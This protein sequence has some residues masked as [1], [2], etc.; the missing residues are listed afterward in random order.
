MHSY[1]LTIERFY[2][3][4]RGIHPHDAW[5]YQQ[6]G[7][8]HLI[9]AEACTWPTE[10]IDN[11]INQRQKWAESHITNL[12]EHGL[13]P[14]I[15]QLM[16][17]QLCSPEGAFQHR[18]STPDRWPHKYCWLWDTA[19][20]AVGWRHFDAECA[21]EQIHALFDQQQEDG[22][23]A[24]Y[25]TPNHTSKISQPPVLAWAVKESI[26][27]RIESCLAGRYLS[28]PVCLYGM[29][30]C[31]ARAAESPLLH[32][33]TNSSAHCPCAESGWDN[34]IRFAGGALLDAVDLSAFA[35]REYAILA[36]F[37]EQ[38]GL[39]DNHN[40][41]QQRH[42][43]MNHA[44]RNDLWSEELGLFCDRDIETEY[45]NA[46]PCRIITRYLRRLRR[47]ANCRIISQPE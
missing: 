35:S 34:S 12:P 38:L 2:S 36:E 47:T 21:R 23:I 26:R 15:L 6:Q 11:L 18:W 8:L 13:T 32:W 27:K 40:T 1:S 20:H 43:A 28:Q 31:P 37:A 14:K 5:N 22:R 16:K 44:I 25:N 19:F 7:D 17:G 41:W 46:H 4:V 45:E 10:T 30:Y 29:V 39:H 9:S 24:H 33:K 3:A 42:E